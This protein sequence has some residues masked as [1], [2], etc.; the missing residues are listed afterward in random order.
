MANGSSSSSR[1]RH[2]QR[3]SSCAGRDAAPEQARI[4]ADTA[5]RA[6]LSNVGFNVGIGNIGSAMSIFGFVFFIQPIM[7]AMLQEMP[8]SLT[9]FELQ[10]QH[11]IPIIAKQNFPGK[12]GD[13]NKDNKCSPE[14]GAWVS[15]YACFFRLMPSTP[16]MWEASAP[17]VKSRLATTQQHQD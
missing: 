2:G 4:S 10:I 12:V 1:L 3:L 8:V 14:I 16:L 15:Y 17:L 13:I 7:M 5:H 9:Q 11:T 6:G